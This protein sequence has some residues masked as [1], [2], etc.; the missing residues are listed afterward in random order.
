[1][2]FLKSQSHPRQ[3]GKEWPVLS[4]LVP[5]GP[6]DLFWWLGNG[7]CPTGSHVLLFFYQRR[8]QKQIVKPEM[9]MSK[10]GFYLPTRCRRHYYTH[11]KY[12]GM[13][14]PMVLKT[15]AQ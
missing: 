15:L 10:S 13:K 7:E 8:F 1:M 4:H 5:V 9:L 6:R 14:V 12:W 11:G 3:G 2:R